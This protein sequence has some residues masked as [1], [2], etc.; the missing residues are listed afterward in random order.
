[1][2]TFDLVVRNAM[3][4]PRRAILTV[5]T[6]AAATFIFTVLVSI[7]ASIDKILSHFSQTLR[8]LSYNADG[9]YLGLP[10]HYCHEI[11]RIPGVVA[12]TPLVYL[13]AIY[14]SEREII[15]AY[16]VDDDKLAVTFPDYDIQ[17][18]VIRDFRHNRVAALAGKLVMQAHHWKVGDAITLRADSN[19]LELRFILV[20]EIPSNNYPN[21]FSFRRDY[22]VEAEKAIGISE[23][24]H[25]PALLATR[26]GSEGEIP[27]V[28]HRIDE[29]FHNSDFE[30][31][32][33]TESE[34][35]AGLMST[36]GNVRGI[37]YAMFVMILVTVLFVAANSM[38]IMVRDRL[39]DVAV[40]RTLGFPALYVAV[41][42]LGECALL[43][44]AGGLLGGA[45]A[46]WQFG[47]ETTLGGVF[48]K[49]GYLTITT[50]AAAEAIVA[51]ISASLLSTIV[52][53]LAALRVPPAEILQKASTL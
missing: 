50:G 42:L 13:R 5:L 43:G 16:A 41:L 23:Q 39:S 14:Q 35:M 4:Q 25:P 44:A 22:L 3:R 53:I 32:T 7:P 36:V 1:M 8:V 27:L 21:F 31:A 24:Q 9:R 29:I 51:A 40:L 46:L 30:T 2:T 48:E 20:G 6:F 33:M 26:V 34:A 10:A 45:V 28:I 17:P 19:R 37:V 12:C 18:N 47:G 15:Q 11:E 49:A 52:P 38:S